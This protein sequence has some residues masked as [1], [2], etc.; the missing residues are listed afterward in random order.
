MKSVFRIFFSIYASKQFR[1]IGCLALAALVEAVGLA[2]LLPVL[3]TIGGGG[4]SKAGAVLNDVF[5]RIGLHPDMLTLTLIIVILMILKAGLSVLAMSYVGYAVADLAT[6]LRLELVARLI[7]ARWSYFVGQPVG[8]ISNIAGLEVTRSAEAYLMSAQ[9]ITLM[10]QAAGYTVVALFISWPIALVAIGGGGAMTLLLQ[11]FVRK[12]RRAGRRQTQRT[13]ELVIQLNDALVGIKPLKAMARH[14]QVIRFLEGKIAELRRALR[15]QTLSKQMT[16]YIQEPL[17]VIFL[18]VG[19]YVT[20]TFWGIPLSELLVMGLLIERTI[21]SVGKV[22]QEV[23]KAAAVESAFW[24]VHR[25]V[26]EA[27]AEAET[28]I[29]TRGPTLTKGCSF[30]HVHFSFGD[31]KVLNDVSIDIPAASVTVITGGSGAGKTT[32]T[33]LLLAL[34]APDG[35]EILIDGA[36]LGEIDVAQWRSMVGYVPQ[37]LILFND[38]IAANV[39]LG[40]PTLSEER[41]V[42]ALTAAGALDFVE[43]LP[44]GIH[45]QVGERGSRLSGGQRQRIAIAR[46]LVHEP[47]LLILDEVTSALDPETEASICRNIRALTARGITALAITHREAWLAAADRVY[48][49]E[50]GVAERLRVDQPA[51]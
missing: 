41:V 15:Q 44:D 20:T 51:A 27:G 36:P 38:S 45:T 12:T 39:T 17:L 10:I 43:K 30:R 16:K 26:E 50:E 14:A 23:Q 48:H 34:H 46:A 31:T 4:E 18:A 6:K 33:D 9:A 32:M 25:L 22:Q 13:S 35:G 2:T 29:G 28:H 21:S 24:S 7:R 49:L 37:E 19:L 8:R 3:N 42:D 40:D 11:R 5:A 47:K 1:I